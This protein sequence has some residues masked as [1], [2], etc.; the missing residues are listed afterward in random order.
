M[1]KTTAVNRKPLEGSRILIVDDQLSAQASLERVLEA[2]GAEVLCV[3]SVEEARRL[4]PLAVVDAAV[5]DYWLPDEVGVEAMR[6]LR[7]HVEPCATV[8]ITGTQ[9]PSLVRECIAEG[10]FDVLIK[11][12]ELDDFITAVAKAVRRTRTWRAT[13]ASTPSAHARDRR[14][15]THPDPLVTGANSEERTKRQS[16]LDRQARD[17]ARTRKLSKKET[18]IFIHVVRGLRNLEIAELENIAERTVKF[19]VAN[20]MT[21]FGVR[22]RSDLILLVFFDES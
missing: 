2:E 19:H 11:P 15:R 21:K 17:L 3:S 6:I 13:V 20:I 7:S 12:F 8:M 14:F 1:A 10:A 5:V 4:V 9:D 18:T 22:S 16:E